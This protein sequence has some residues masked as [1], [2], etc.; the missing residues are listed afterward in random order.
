MKKNSEQLLETLK[1]YTNII[2]F[3]KGS[4]DPDAI[5]SSL[6]IKTICESLGIKNTIHAEKKI[7]LPQNKALVQTLDIPVKFSFPQDLSRFNAYMVFDHQSAQINVSSTNNIPCAVHI[8]HHDKINDLNRCDF[9][10]IM[11][12]A[13]S[14]SSIIALLLKEMDIDINRQTMT[15]ICTALLYGIETDTDGY[16]HAGTMDYEAIDFLSSYSDMS[17]IKKISSIPLSKKTVSLLWKAMENLHLYKDWLMTG[18]GFIPESN[19]DSIAIIADF[20]TKRE[21]ASVIIVFAA[22]EKSN[23]KGLVLDASLRSKKDT[24]NLNAIIKE[25]T[26]EGGARKYKGA[27]QIDMNYFS[28]CPDKNLLWKLITL[29]TID[30]LQKRRD[31]IYITE[32]KRHYLRIKDKFFGFMQK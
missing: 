6:A 25:I 20:L 12:D 16:S 9:R 22:I 10:L 14:T 2:T 24:T 13:G 30:V 1:K 18:I 29:T 21:E 5:A 3:I 4:P 19:R 27:F 23:G 8:D 17:L 28:D 32:I 7:S 15:R 31:D 11:T 26:S